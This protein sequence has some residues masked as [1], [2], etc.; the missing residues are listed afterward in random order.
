MGRPRKKPRPPE[1]KDDDIRDQI[2]KFLHTT[3][4]KAR[5]AAATYATMGVIKSAM[6]SLNVMQHRIVSNLTYLVQNRW[7]E[8]KE[9]RITIRPRGRPPHCPEG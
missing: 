6:K 8:E 9:E 2:L 5:S 7:V 1:L 3:Y 4:R